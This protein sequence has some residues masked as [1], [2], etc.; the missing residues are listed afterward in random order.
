MIR[1]LIQGYMLLVAAVSVIGLVYVYVFPD[2][3][4]K[5]SREGVAY[6]SPKVV[7]PDTDKP[8]TLD[9]LIRHYR[10]D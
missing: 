9:E 5:K 2:P 10:G 7:N 8:L 4:M 1:Y 3:A 6:F